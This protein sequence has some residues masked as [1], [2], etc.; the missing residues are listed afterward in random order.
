MKVPNI[1]KSKVKKEV[2]TPPF[3]WGRGLHQTLSLLK[4]LQALLVLLLGVEEL[5]IEPIGANSELLQD[6]DKARISALDVENLIDMS[7]N[8]WY[9]QVNI[10]SGK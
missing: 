3:L 7:L 8:I 1:K 10:I 2:L 9:V 4:K 5:V 6:F